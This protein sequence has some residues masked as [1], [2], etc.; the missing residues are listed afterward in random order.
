MEK[1]WSETPKED[2]LSSSPSNTLGICSQSECVLFVPASPPLLHLV[3][4]CPKGKDIPR[5]PI[6]DSLSQQYLERKPVPLWPLLCL[7]LNAC[8]RQHL[9]T[10]S[11]E[12]GHS[13]TGS[14]GSMNFPTHVLHYVWRYEENFLICTLLFL[15]R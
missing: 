2:F 1:D 6:P 9:G 11:G 5:T 8:R 13:V 7:H 14:D 4:R 15:I 12:A 10:A 3:C